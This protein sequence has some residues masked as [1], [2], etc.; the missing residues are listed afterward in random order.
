VLLI[1]YDLGRLTSVIRIAVRNAVDTGR[2]SLYG[3]SWDADIRSRNGIRSSYPRTLQGL[4]RRH[5]RSVRPG[6]LLI[7]RAS[8][9]KLI[10]SAAIRLRRASRTGRGLMA[11][12]KTRSAAIENKFPSCRFRRE[13]A[14][15]LTAPRLRMSEPPQSELYVL[16]TMK[17]IFARMLFEL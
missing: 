14:G 4:E 8:R 16:I 3:A 12:V 9:N 13:F 7:A 1:Q 17:I 10:Y 6:V 15:I 11:G 5:R 2:S